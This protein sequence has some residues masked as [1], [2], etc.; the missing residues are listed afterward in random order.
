MA[1]VF[2]RTENELNQFRD[3]GE[4]QRIMRS[5]FAGLRTLDNTYN[6]ISTMLSPW[7]W[8]EQ[9]ESGPRKGKYKMWRNIEKMVPVLSRVGTSN[10]DR[11]N[12]LDSNLFGN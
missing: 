4:F 9:Y 12:F 6:L 7:D 8:G 3:F 10:E 5:P 2:K 1:F 11:Y